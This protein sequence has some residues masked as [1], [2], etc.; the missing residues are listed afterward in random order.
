V[1][2]LLGSAW[3]LFVFAMPIYGTAIGLSASTIGLILSAFALATFIVRMA[4][5]WISRRLREWSTITATMGSPAWP[6]CSSRS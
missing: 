5:P 6:T 2:G 4:L 1:T 3:D